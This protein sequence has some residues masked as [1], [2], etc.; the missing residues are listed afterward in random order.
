MDIKDAVQIKPSDY[1]KAINTK[2]FQFVQKLHYG[3]QNWRLREIE[4]LQS[5]RM[6]RD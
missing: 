2:E 6:A 5:R 1:S 3:V 4:S